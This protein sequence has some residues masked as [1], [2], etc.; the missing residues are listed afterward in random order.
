MKEIYLAGGCFWGLQ[1]FFDCVSGV[2]ETEVGYANG[3]LPNP[4]Y[5][6][7]CS[8][9]TGF[10][11]TV[12]VR[13]DG[14]ALPLA[15]I[16]ELYFK[17]IDPTVKDRQG[18]DR[19]SQ[20][21]TGIYYVDD[22]DR[23]EILAFIQEQ[24]AHYAQ[25]IVTEVL[26]LQNFYAAEDY[27]QKYL[28]KNPHGYCHLD[29]EAFALA[30]EYRYGSSDP[31]RERLTR[32]QYAVLVKGATEPPFSSEYVENDREGI[33]VDAATGEPLF[34]SFDQ[35]NSGCGWPSF[36]KPL[37][38][39]AVVEHPMMAFGHQ[40]TE[41]RSNVGNFHL[42]H[43]FNDG[44]P[45]RGGLRYCI[46]GAALKFIAREDLAKEGYDYLLPYLEKRAKEE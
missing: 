15:G 37:T 3:N 36:T 29:R 33:Y 26:P 1:K 42:G 41:V 10:A 34:A 45:E 19:G 18:N 14:A 11:E 25:P 40:R 17:V 6:Q 7:V 22:Q 12:R 13:Y 2:E 24:Q 46:N 27:H 20:Y 38:A 23:P 31:L 39:E 8:G 44:P 9:Q 43:V 16:L 21:R 30:K 5:R 4:S 32:Q 28:D 35:Y